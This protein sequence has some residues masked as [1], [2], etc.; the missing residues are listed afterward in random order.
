MS[1][2]EITLSQPIEWGGESIAVLRLR[3]PKAKDFRTLKNM[4]LPFSMMLDFAAELSDLPS[5]AIDLLDVDDVPKLVAV[6]SGFLGTSQGT[7]K[8]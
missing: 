1:T 4:E 3:R 5:A 7:G 8:T 6:I 2:I